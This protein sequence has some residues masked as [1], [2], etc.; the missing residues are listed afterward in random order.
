[1]VFLCHTSAVLT[2]SDIEPKKMAIPKE[3]QSFNLPGL[4]PDVADDGSSR[5]RKRPT[6]YGGTD[7]ETT[8]VSTERR[9]KRNTKKP[10]PKGKKKRVVEDPSATPRTAPQPPKEAVTTPDAA[11]DVIRRLQQTGGLPQMPFPPMPGQ[12]GQG[13]Q[14]VFNNFNV[15]VLPDSKK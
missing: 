10:K 4:K 7:S 2:F 9:R 6:V 13:Q 3:L 11:W 14:F 12:P 1:V 5:T 8:P 15:F